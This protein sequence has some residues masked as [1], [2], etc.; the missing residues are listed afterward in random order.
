MKIDENGKIFE[1][2]EL[3]D[4]LPEE[5]EA[6]N[7][8]NL[9]EFHESLESEKEINSNLSFTNIKDEDKDSK[10]II[11]DLADNSNNETIS[12]NLSEQISDKIDTYDND[13]EKHNLPEENKT[14]E[15]TCL[16]LTVR[17]DYNLS[18]LKNSVLKTF[19]VTLKV[20][21]CTFFLNLL[22]LFL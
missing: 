14:A 2:I 16:A 17:K 12:N 18:V 11:E 4:K 9:D 10:T 3:Q 20:T 6:E 15:T 22:S 8:N 1:E 13:F 21:L 7:L 19:K 5:K